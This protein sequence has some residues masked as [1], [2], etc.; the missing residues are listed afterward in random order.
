MVR[1]TAVP[2][3]IYRI[4]SPL[5]AA[6]QMGGA[7]DESQVSG[8]HALPPHLPLPLWGGELGTGAW[9]WPDALA[10]APS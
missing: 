4:K 5:K 8:S 10:I 7:G 1:V 2:F 3:Y 6:S 9:A